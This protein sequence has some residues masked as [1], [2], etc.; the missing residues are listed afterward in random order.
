MPRLALAPTT[1]S[2]HASSKVSNVG[3]I[4]SPPPGR[5][6]R[7]RGGAPS[8]SPAMRWTSVFE[9]GEPDDLARQVGER[10]AAAGQQVQGGAVGGDVD[11]ER[12]EHAQLLVDDVVGDETGGVRRAPGA[13]DDDGAP[14]ASEGDRLGE[15]GRRLR[16]DVDDDVGEAAGGGAQRPDGVVGRP[17]RR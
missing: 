6:R 3:R 11:A 12:A 15:R 2:A 4:T 17:R 13:G 7:G 9:P 8:P 1:R 14:G 16:R 10:V 5:T